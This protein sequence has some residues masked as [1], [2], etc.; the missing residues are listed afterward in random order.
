MKKVK[1]ILFKVEM[2]GEGIVNFDS[3][4]QKFINKQT[5]LKG[6]L[7][8]NNVSYA[9]KN[10]YAAGLDDKG[11]PKLDYKIKI[12]ADCLR[13]EIFSKYT[14]SQTPNLIHS[15]PL[16]LS[17]IASPVSVLRG[18]LFA[19]TRETIKRK[20]AI[21]LTDMEQTNNAVSFVETF[22]RSGK[23]DSD[24][25]DDVSDTSFFKKERVGKITYAG[26]G[27]IDLSELQFVS[28][29]AIFDRYAFNPDDFAIY[30]SLMNSHLDDNFTSEL[31]YYNMASNVDKLPEFGYKFS[32][33]NI[34][35]LVKIFMSDLRRAQIKRNTGIANVTKVQYKFVYDVLED[36]FNNPDNWISLDTQV[37]IDAIDFETIDT[38][39]EH[40]YAAAEKLREDLVANEIS[41]KNLDRAKKA[42]NKAATA[43]TKTKKTTTTDNA[44]VK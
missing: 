30:K 11:N 23:K 6:H 20:G 7:I 36:T 41:N 5:D 34:L 4:D 31:G 21:T 43:T 16:L 42:A 26:R 44:D 37:D 35:K 13:H 17:Y 15:K 22:S 3:G 29:D 8:Y 32:N 25:D 2:D 19:N 27:V 40:D 33:T 18:Y 1:S 10:Y 28:T 39:V 38:Y 24:T 14:V 12:S 9:K